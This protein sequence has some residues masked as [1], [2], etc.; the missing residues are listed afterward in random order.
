[1]TNDNSPPTVQVREASD[2]PQRSSADFLEAVRWYNPGDEAGQQSAFNQ[3]FAAP[4]LSHGNE[5]S[6]PD[7]YQVP[8]SRDTLLAPA[9]VGRLLD[10][11]RS[12]NPSAPLPDFVFRVPY[13]A[14]GTKSSV[15]DKTVEKLLILKG[16]AISRIKNRKTEDDQKILPRFR[17]FSGSI[18]R[19]LMAQIDTFDFQKK[20]EKKRTFVRIGLRSDIKIFPFYLNMSPLLKREKESWSFS[21]RIPSGDSAW[22][23]KLGKDFLDRFSECWLYYEIVFDKDF[24]KFRPSSGKGFSANRAQNRSSALIRSKIKDLYFPSAPEVNKQ[25]IRKIEI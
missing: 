1:M 23:R 16:E 24:K 19:E 22:E 7:G 5:S 8:D 6:A 12:P 18:G 25:Q 11:I 17:L 2:T 13:L 4:P 21:R 9:V 10:D 20:G 3:T 15:D 14:P